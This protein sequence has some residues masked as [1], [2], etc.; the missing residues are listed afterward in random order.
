[1]PRPAVGSNA[2]SV[3]EVASRPPVQPA[4]RIWLARGAWHRQSLAI[5]R[6]KNSNLLRV[7]EDVVGCPAGQVEPRPV[8]QEAE[9]GR[10]EVGTTL[11]CQHGVQFFAQRMQIK[12]IGRGV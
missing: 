7:S 11:A 5:K 9:T 2:Y 4:V 10:G 12:H 8:G 3:R 1:M 6:F